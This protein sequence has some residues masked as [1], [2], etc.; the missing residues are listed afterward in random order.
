MPVGRLFVPHSSRFTAISAARA[1]HSR[2]RLAPARPR[3][4]RAHERAARA[5]P[6]ATMA[7]AAPEQVSAN[8]QFGGAAAR[9]WR[10]VAADAAMRTREQRGRVRTELHSWASLVA[11]CTPSQHLVC[12]RP[13]PASA[14]LARH[15]QAARAGPRCSRQGALP[16]A[17]PGSAHPR[18]HSTPATPRPPQ[19]PAPPSPRLEPPLQAH[20]L[21]PRLPHELHGVLPARRRGAWREGPGRVVP[22]G[23]H[24]H[25][26]KRYPEERRAARVRGARRRAR[27]ARHVAARA[28]RRGRGRGVGLRRRRGWVPAPRA[29][30]AGGARGAGSKGAHSSRPPNPLPRPQR[31]TPAPSQPAAL[32]L[33]PPPTA[34]RPNCSLA[35]PRF[36]PGFY[37]NA[38]VD[39]WK[40]WRMYDYITKVG[41]TRARWC[42]TLCLPTRVRKPAHLPA[43]PDA[44]LPLCPP[45][46]L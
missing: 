36:L 37:I 42:I 41:R 45:G 30:A 4:A 6:V 18:P 16:T 12:N 25:R 23:P 5:L 14:S 9:S 8:K 24:L 44:V 1:H 38:T 27:R 22:V 28:G 13:P 19:P 21:V 29:A 10:R 31:R 33:A 32:L 11:A 7:A 26:R 46:R 35:R 17:A 20:Q 39:K 2:L 40:N 15:A 34:R 3:L 43:C